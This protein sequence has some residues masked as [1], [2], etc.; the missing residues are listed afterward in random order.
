M[1]TLTLKS[2]YPY[3]FTTD[4]RLDSNVELGFHEPVTA[5][6]GQILFFQGDQ[7]IFAIDI[8]GPHVRLEGAKVTIDPPVDFEYGKGYR[9]EV[10][11]GVIKAASGDAVN[12][13]E[14]TYFNAV[15]TTV[16]LKVTGSAADESVIGGS[17]N[18]V[19]DGAGGNDTLMGW[20]GDDILRGGDGDDV[21]DGWAG[22]DVLEGG[23]G[24]DR[25]DDYRGHNTLRGG[26]GNDTLLLSGMESSSADGGDGDDQ[27]EGTVGMTLEGGNGN[28]SLRLG[29]W[30]KQGVASASGGDG[31]DTLW[32]GNV[33]GELSAT[34]AGGAGNDT[35]TF[36]AWG[37][38]RGAHVITD[39]EPGKDVL[40]FTS[41]SD[42]VPDSNLFAS[43]YLSA[44]QRGADTLISLDQDGPG[45][46]QS[47]PAQYVTLKNV[48]LASLTAADFAGN[49]DPHRGSTPQDLQGTAG[50]DLLRGST[51]DDAIA[52]NG[53]DD[54]ID[55]NSGNDKL[56]GGA[57]NDA[58]YGGG[59]DDT[60]D[61][62]DGDDGLADDSGVNLL[63]GGAGNDTARIN[64][65]ASTVFGDAGEDTFHIAGGKATVD[66]GA[67]RDLIIAAGARPDITATGGAG[68][69]VFQFNP[70]L[71]TA[72]TITDFTAGKEGDF[73][74]PFSLFARDSRPIANLFGTGQA[75]LQQSGADTWLQ[76]DIDGPDGAGA[77]KTVAVLK[78]I[79]ASALT[80]DNFTLN[81]DPAGIA[82]GVTLSGYN[83][84]DELT[85]GAYDDVLYGGAG[86]DSL[87]GAG[88]ND[89][90]YGGGADDRLYGGDGNDT[91]N[92]DDGNDLLYGFAGNDHIHGGAGLDH[93]YFT[94]R[95]KYDVSSSGGVVTVREKASGEADILTG[96]E[97]L[98]F[99]DALSGV[100]TVAFDLDG[101]AGKVY[102]LYQAAYDRKPDDWGFNFWLYN[103]DRGQ[104]MAEIAGYFTAS[105]EFKQLY[106]NTPDNAD[107]VTR[108]YHNVL[109]RE[110]EPGG[111][112]FW[113]AA[114]NTKGV[115]QLQL[116]NI[117]AESPENVANVAR[118]VG[119][120][121]SFYMPSSL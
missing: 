6:A 78:N 47:A 70:E 105:D 73:L 21:L 26:A 72:M 101:N 3:R 59:G 8:N 95:S 10:P 71:E 17:A 92:G 120:S 93:A 96:V 25:L 44:E 62:G 42:G 55:G 37:T 33:E 114:L 4:A 16:P 103:A 83:G 39:F 29:S 23:D 45:G 86:Y 65:G 118:I 54:R 27:L 68:R 107:F 43:G 109:H 99:G 119:D 32:V 18:D 100:T 9:V 31:N 115:T 94:Y 36:S 121:V 12:G 38:V 67:D 76:A 61:G 49:L 91:L 5:G 57:G 14:Y 34:L 75:R 112:N 111:Y 81:I 1:P 113:M 30:Q 52:G 80:G 22:D 85:G 7:Q 116:L 102:R 98:Q 15:R 104:T 46:S 110:P 97:R 84:N 77:F 53:G 64:G 108:L 51:L 13:N 19:L 66:G 28:D 35:F 40:D 50:D 79:Q 20:E 60:I 74:D 88:G 56:A 2:I 87:A 82:K 58:L 63:H 11:A 69:D 48:A 89:T 106:G 24:N 90:L 117:F 41:F